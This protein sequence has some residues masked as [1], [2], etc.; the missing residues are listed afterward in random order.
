MKTET[1]IKAECWDIYKSAMSDALMGRVP[2]RLNVAE[3]DVV[4]QILIGMG[5]VEDTVRKAEGEK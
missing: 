4:M 2:A 5:Q 1:E 3:R